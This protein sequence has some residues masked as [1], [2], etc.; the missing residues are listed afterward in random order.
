MAMI[1][2][3][4]QNLYMQ[5]LVTTNFTVNTTFAN[6]RHSVSALRNHLGN[7]VSFPTTSTDPLF[8]DR[9]NWKYLVSV[10]FEGKDSNRGQLYVNDVR[11][12]DS[13]TTGSGTNRVTTAWG[14]APPVDTVVGT[15]SNGPLIATALL[16]TGSG[17]VKINGTLKFDYVRIRK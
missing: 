2:D 1:A 4:H 5:P 14:F 16:L 17:N 12:F 9:K 15:N 10:E 3:F 13:Y 8:L 6:L 7:P 11:I